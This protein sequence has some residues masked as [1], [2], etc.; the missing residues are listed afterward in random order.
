M[1]KC[2][3]EICAKNCVPLS[4]HLFFFCWNHAEETQQG[5]NISP[6]LL[7]HWAQ[8]FPYAYCSCLYPLCGESGTV[9]H[10]SNIKS[11]VECLRKIH[12]TIG[13]H[14]NKPKVFKIRY[15][16]YT[17][18]TFISFQNTVKFVVQKLLSIT[19]KK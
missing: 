4:S 13:G 10:I 1:L 5:L 18:C 17:T 2:Y 7:V 9:T 6:L 14:Q 12:C 11:F 15:T 19:L 3:V 8:R 16:I